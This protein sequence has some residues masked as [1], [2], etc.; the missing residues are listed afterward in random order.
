MLSLDDVAGQLDKVRWSGRNSLTASCPV[1]DDRSPSLSVTLGDDGTVLACCHAGCPQSEVARALGLGGRK[2]RVPDLRMVRPSKDYTSTR[3]A[4]VELMKRTRPMGRLSHRYLTEK[5]IEVCGA[6]MIHEHRGL[7][8]KL[9]GEGPFIVL[10]MKDAQG[11]LWDC[12]LIGMRGTKCFLPGPKKPG[13]FFPIKGTDDIWL[14]EGYATGCSLHMD[15]GASVAV[16]FDCGGL[17]RVARALFKAFPNRTLRVMA[18]DDAF[19]KGNPGVT[20]A[21]KVQAEVGIEVC[22]PNWDGVARTE[23]D[24]DFNDLSRLKNDGKHKSA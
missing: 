9:K 18:D 2:N 19:T 4:A 11:K 5:E 7:P 17:L 8:S 3:N 12:Q 23:N 10:P 20:A 15:T 16:A 1:H 21:R 13:T 6:K 14:C 22:L 24:T